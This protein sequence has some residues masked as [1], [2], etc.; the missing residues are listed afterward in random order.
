MTGLWRKVRLI[1]QPLQSTASLFPS[2]YLYST[3]LHLLSVLMSSRSHSGCFTGSR[4]E[5]HFVSFLWSAKCCLKNS[6]L[7]G[8]FKDAN[9]RTNPPPPPRMC[10]I[11]MQGGMGGGVLSAWWGYMLHYSL[12][13]EDNEEVHSAPIK[14]AA[15]RPMD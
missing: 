5:L 12:S 10:Q 8:T 11:N 7:S 6:V 14:A 9:N 1:M 4:C 15:S 13:R 2:L 3:S